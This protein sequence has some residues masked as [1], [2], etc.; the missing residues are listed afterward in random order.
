MNYRC[1]YF[2]LLCAM[3]VSSVS[4]Q[5]VVWSEDF[6]GETN[7]VQTGTAAGSP[8]GTWSV[9]TS[10]SGGSGSFSKQDVPIIGNS[11]QINQ[12]GDEGVWATNVIDVSAYGYVVV[13]ITLASG[14]LGFSGAD[15]IQAYYKAN[16]GAEVLFAEI[17]GAFLSA[18]TIGSALIPASSTVQII[19][20]GV[21]NSNFCCGLGGRFVFDDLSVTGISTLY[22][23][24]S[25]SWTTNGTW[26]TASIGGASCG[27]TPNNLTRVVVGSP[28]TVTIPNIGGGNAEAIDVE[29]RTGG[30]L[31]FS[32]N[33]VLNINRGG[34]V[35]VQS[36]A[37]LSSGANT[38]AQLA[39][40]GDYNHAVTVDGAL[41]IGDID[42]NASQSLTISGIGALTISDDFLMDADDAVVTNS[43][44][45]VVNVLDQLN[46]EGSDMTFNNNGNMNVLGA[47]GIVFTGDDNTLNN[48]ST[49]TATGATRS[50][51]F[52]NGATGNTVSN[53][54]TLSLTTVYFDDDNNTV[55]NSNSL[56]ISGNIQAG[57]NDDGC[58]IN[59]TG[60]LGFAGIS[61]SNANLTIN[62]SGTIN[63]S[64]NFTN[65][66]IDTG[67][68]FNNQAG[69][70]WN[71]TLTPNTTFDTSMN[72]VLD[73][74]ST[75]NTFNYGGAGA[76]R[77]IPTQYNNL[78]LSNAG[79]KDAN[80][81]SWS[82]S[83]NWL[84]S[85]SASFTEGTGTIT[86]NGATNQTVTNGS[87]ETFYNL[88]VNKSGGTTLN[89]N[90]SP[91]TNL[92]V[93]NALTLT[94]GIVNTTS[95]Q[96]LTLNNNATASSGNASS[97]VDGPMRK[98]GNSP[99]PFV[100]PTGDGSI[101]AR[102]G[103][104]YISGS[105]ATT[106]F[107]AQYFDAPYSDLTNDVS[108][109]NASYVEY[110]TLDQAVTSAT[111]RVQLFWENG[112][113]SDINS[114]TADLVVAKYTSP[115]WASAGQSA[116][117]GN[118]TAGSV[119]SNNV[120]SFSPFT[121]GSLSSALNPLPVELLSFTANANNDQIELDWATA[122]ELNND[123]FTI[124]RS[125]DAETFE[126]VVILKGNGTTSDR[127]EYHATDKDPIIGRSYY[128]LKQ[129]DFDGTVTYSD[130]VRVEYEGPAFATLRA[131]PNPSK[132]N[133]L[134]LQLKGVNEVMDVPVKIVSMKGELVFEGILHVD[135]TGKSTEEIEFD[136][137][138]SSGLYIVKAGPGVF[139]T[140]KVAVIR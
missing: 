70:T 51:S 23:R 112:T 64:G 36:G 120:T 84:V 116:I 9:T 50:I 126:K 53:S 89:L 122:S 72:T 73:C 16:G 65:N 47:T 130:L 78:T 56:T 26:S 105:N 57:T 106:Q 2:L 117:T 79:A 101:W 128:R 71:W 85:G 108:L 109:N 92:T 21:D 132:G 14:G 61:I 127:H 94:N 114:V 121:F 10:P 74:S 68:S 1:L 69:G 17:S 135:E 124:E 20:R 129:T 98:I 119:T 3:G 86:M 40:N 80:N 118:T 91:S 6:E 58:I 44:S 35:T 136:E 46:F 54:G 97:Y 63:Q 43:M 99:D 11:F 96:L 82:V 30:T 39:Y 67:S 107:T 87:G 38:G 137:P 12:T 33:E 48:T 138:L 113:R 7:G 15:Y 93:T 62:N 37:T 110:W 60:T 45:G 5:T 34:S 104:D 76:Q 140:Q 111:A 88:T 131:F 31:S 24:A 8:G 27:C 77:I 42:M 32:A 29:V 18:S 59:N 52:E 139:L 75:G 25:S 134:T 83:G 103:V 22:S 102:I 115:D 55:T 90:T 49:L 41:T 66:T 100:F 125:I 13:D 123:F 81:A 95:S 4:A 28:H 133:K 19:V